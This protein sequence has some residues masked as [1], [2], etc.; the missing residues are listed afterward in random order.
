[1]KS[2]NYDT[3]K[4]DLL[5]VG[6]GGRHAVTIPV[7]AVIAAEGQE[8]VFV[9]RDGGFVRMLITAGAR[10]DQFVE[11]RRGLKAGERVVTDG[12][13]QVYTKMLTMQRGGVAMGGHAH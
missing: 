7:D 8:F 4:C 10:N 2:Q 9:E 1:M 5:V 13:R 6:G 3:K 12:K 11:V